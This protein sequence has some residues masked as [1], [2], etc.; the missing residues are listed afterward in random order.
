[1]KRLLIS[2]LLVMILSAG[3]CESPNKSQCFARPGEEAMPRFSNQALL[4]EFLAE[5]LCAPFFLHQRSSV[6]FLIQGGSLFFYRPRRKK[7]LYR[8]LL[9]HIFSLLIRARKFCFPSPKNPSLFQ[10]L[11][12]RACPP[13]LLPRRQAGQ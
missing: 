5:R 1:M 2:P 8:R 7:I 11:F 3:S 10:H 12:R 4:E 9:P 13:K 6:L